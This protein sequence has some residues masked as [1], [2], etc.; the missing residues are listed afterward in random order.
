MK[1]LELALTACIKDSLDRSSDRFI[2]I[3]SRARL[4]LTE[5]LRLVSESVHN[6]VIGLLDREYESLFDSGNLTISADAS[7]LTKLRNQTY[8][9]RNKSVVL[10]GSANGPYQ[11]GLRQLHTVIDTDAVCTAF[12]RSVLEHIERNHRATDRRIREDLVLSLT[13][14]IRQR[15]LTLYNV[16][17]YLQAAFGTDGGAVH[18]LQENLWRLNLCPDQSFVSSVSLADRIDFNWG[19]LD[20]LRSDHDVLGPKTKRLNQSTHPKVMAF[21]RWLESNSDDDLANSDLEEVLAAL[22]TGPKP[23]PSRIPEILEV[24]ADRDVKDR[25]EVLRTLSEELVE[26]DLIEDRLDK[27]FRSPCEFRV[28]IRGTSTENDPWTLFTSDEPEAVIG[29][30]QAVSVVKIRDIEGRL[31]NAEIREVPL[32]RMLA[33][34]VHGD[35]LDEY[36]RSRR[37]VLRHFSLLASNS[38]QSLSLLV[39]SPTVLGRCSAYVEAWKRLLRNFLESPATA[40]TKNLGIH[41]GLLDGIWTRDA[42]QGEDV[43]NPVTHKDNLFISVR[44][45]PI[46]PWRLGP[47]VNLAHQILERFEDEPAFVNSAMWALDRAIPTFRVLQIGRNTLEY[48]TMVSG[49]VEFDETVDNALPPISTPGSLL[50]RALRTYARTNPWSRA[51]AAIAFFNAPAGGIMG[52]LSATMSTESGFGHD[53]ALVL[54]R[55][56]TTKGLERDSSLPEVIVSFDVPDLKSWLSQNR[57]ERD[58]TIY[59]MPGMRGRAA[60]LGLGS[61]GT[62]DLILASRG[63]DA[64]GQSMSVPQLKLAPEPDN[65]IVSLLHNV[66]GLDDVKS[67]VFNLT[68]PPTVEEI[69]PHVASSTGWLIVGAPAFISAFQLSDSSGNQMSQ[70]AEFDEGAYRFFVFASSI[71]PLGEAVRETVERLPIATARLS[72]IKEIVNGLTATNPQ[73]VFDIALNRFGSEEALGLMCAREVAARYLKPESLTLEISLDNVSWTKQW[74]ELDSRR[75]DLILVSFS[76]DPHAEAPV[77][78]LIVEAKADT[79]SEFERPRTDLAPFTEAIEQVEA[80]RS[81]LVGLFSRSDEGLVESLQLRTLIEQIAAKAGSRYLID[82]RSNRDDLFN[83]YFTQISALSRRGRVVPRIKTLVCTTYLNGVQNA[84]IIEDEDLI[85]ASVSSKLLEEVL[86]GHPM[87]EPEVRHADSIEDTPHGAENNEMGLRNLPEPGETSV[88]RQTARDEYSARDVDDLVSNLSRA[89]RLRSESVQRAGDISTS[90]GPTFLTISFPF[91]R[92]AQ[93]APLQ[94]AETDIA[95]DL[96]VSSVEVS[97]SHEIG[98]IQVLVP[99]PDRQFPPLTLDLDGIITDSKYLSLKIGQNLAGETVHSQISS[100]PHA[101]VSGTTGSGKT[102][103][104]RS[105]LAQLNHWGPTVSQAVIVDGKGETDYFGILAP[106]MFVPE[107]PDPL[108]EANQAVEVLTWLKDV[109]VPR[110]KRLIREIAQ[111][112]QSRVDAKALFIDSIHTGSEPVIRPLIVVIDEF[113]ELMIRGGQSKAAFVDGVTSVAQAAR[114]VLVHLVLATQRPDRTV[115][116]GSIKANLPVRVAFRLPTAADSVTVLGH[117]GAEKLLGLGDM[118][119][120]MN[121]EEDKRLQSFIHH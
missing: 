36:F 66:V 107:Y 37:E 1:F 102:T 89:L 101:L 116:P 5:S 34:V 103:F 59:F 45:L 98:R 77:E 12:E 105:L 50:D 60:E 120:Q 52:R 111:S 57:F 104:M 56:R 6:L 99:R 86:G 61:H 14:L 71:E 53:P 115:V 30:G 93:I 4:P 10:I 41:L 63:F 35:V 97:N 17:Q 87:S 65:D 72:R 113:N 27:S 44:L 74:F 9:N 95:R 13:S 75:A 83:R 91:E 15:K 55:D 67:A 43:R 69:I 40:T 79:S 32:R 106:S 28:R 121:G 96:G 16:D 31:H 7:Y 23:P 8:S 85:L 92:G 110:R 84:Q 49:F 82:E 19:V 26:D 73:K 117:G 48:S 64:R 11:S 33:G 29:D 3:D 100:W 108:L 78:I 42:E 54:I 114:S 90:V 20:D 39:S 25:G 24:L 119:F 118:L 80:T 94:R 46:H 81:L 58:V 62:I 76:T 38:D 68:L 70:L 21:V 51:G 47:L 2:R 18:H 109:E 88:G 112:S 22:R